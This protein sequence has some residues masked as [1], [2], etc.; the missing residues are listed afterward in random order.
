MRWLA[1]G[2]LMNGC[3]GCDGWLSLNSE[4]APNL[5][6][7]SA[8]TSVWISPRDCRSRMQTLSLYQLCI[9]VQI[10]EVHGS[11]LEKYW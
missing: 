8:L 1:Y 9:Y 6:E 10:K 11:V 5:Q 7:D 2:W 4:F 3:M